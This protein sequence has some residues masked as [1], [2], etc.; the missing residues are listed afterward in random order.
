MIFPSKCTIFRSQQVL[1][2][3]PYS[4][5]GPQVVTVASWRPSLGLL[6][7]QNIIFQEKFAKYVSLWISLHYWFIHIFP[8]FSVIFNDQSW[9][10]CSSFYGAVVNVTALPFA[11]FWEERK[12]PGNTTLYS[13]TD[14][15]TLA[16]I[17][18]ALNFTPYVVPTT[19]WAEVKKNHSFIDL[20]DRW[21]KK[22]YC[23]HFQRTI[24]EKV[25]WTLW[26]MPQQSD[27]FVFSTQ[28]P[29]SVLDDFENNFGY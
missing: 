21:M 27:L 18:N 14:F 22:M 26:W 10:Y 8:L 28:R 4:P 2:Y 3:L 16:A 13:G 5:V 6:P 24:E 12:G 9:T 20:D 25:V 15:Y 11:P 29:Q 17:A 1:R 23:I 7:A 19:S